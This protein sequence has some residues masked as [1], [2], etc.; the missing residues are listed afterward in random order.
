MHV[1]LL[2]LKPQY[3]SI[4]HRMLPLLAELLESQQFILGPH[5]DRIEEA[6]ARH[7]RAH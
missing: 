6:I 4:K 7:P 5:V 1:P 2:D 3:E